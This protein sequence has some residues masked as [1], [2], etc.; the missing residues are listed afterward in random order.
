MR[1]QRN[2]KKDLIEVA[3]LCAAM[4]IFGVL[5]ARGADVYEYTTHYGFTN[6]TWTVAWDPVATATEYEYRVFNFERKV[7]MVIGRTSQTQVTVNLPKTG[8]WV[9]EVRSFDGTLYSETW[10]SSI[11]DNY[12]S[13]KSWW[14]FTWLA[15]PGP[16]G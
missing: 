2:L 5:A 14:I 7:Y 3:L 6:D 8:H 9:F 10:A 15:P 12:A 11:D 16:I 4:L 13:P 1:N